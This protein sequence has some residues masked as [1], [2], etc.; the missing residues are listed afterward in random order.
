ML[1]RVEDSYL[2]MYG[3]CKCEMEKESDVNWRIWCDDYNNDIFKETILDNLL[4]F[5][6]SY[7]H[8]FFFK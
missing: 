1:I 2:L 5:I 7:F 3:L 8:I 6:F 4:I